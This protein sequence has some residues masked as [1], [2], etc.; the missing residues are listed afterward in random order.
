MGNV[1]V[2]WE[3]VQ[4][5]LDKLIAERDANG[6]NKELARRIHLLQKR[7][8]YHRIHPRQEVPWNKTPMQVFGKHIKDMTPDELR[9]YQTTMYRMRKEAQHG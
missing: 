2:N 4:E 8:S 1:K 6:T 9:L 3:E 5:E 7:L